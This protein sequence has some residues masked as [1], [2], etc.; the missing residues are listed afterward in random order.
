MLLICASNDKVL[1]R[2]RPKHL[3]CLDTDIQNLSNVMEGQFNLT[4]VFFNQEV[5]H[6]S[7]EQAK[8]GIKR[9]GRRVKLAVNS[10]AMELN[11]MLPKNRTFWKK[12][13]NEQRGSEDRTLWNASSNKCGISF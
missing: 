2:M 13:N 3:T 10:V 1:S 11:P 5:S 7:T 9:F 8:M 12:I 6:L 4:R